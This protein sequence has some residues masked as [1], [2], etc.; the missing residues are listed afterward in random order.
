VEPLFLSIYDADGG[1]F[2]EGNQTLQGYF[3]RFHFSEETLSTHFLFLGSTGTGKTNAIIQFVNI[4]KNEMMGKDD[5]MI[6]FDTKGDYYSHFFDKNRG[7]VVISNLDFDGK[8]NWNIFEEIKIDEKSSWGQDAL[9]ISLEIFDE[10][11]RNS[12]DQYFPM[13]AMDVTRASLIALLLNSDKD[14][15]Q[16]TNRDLYKTLANSGPEELKNLI[17]TYPDLSGA[18]I[19]IRDPYSGQTQGVMGEIKQSME[20]IFSGKFGQPGN[21]SVRRFVRERGGKTLFIEYDSTYGKLLTPVYRLLIDLSIKEALG[22]KQ[23]G[24]RNVYFVIDE[25]GLL[26]NLYHIEDAVNFGRGLGVKFLVGT[27]SVNQVSSSY[28]NERAKSILASFG[29]V[30]GFRLNDKESKEIIANRYG[31][32]MALLTKKSQVPSEPLFHTVVKS[33][34]VEPL[35]ISLLKTGQSIVS[36]SGHKPHIFQFRKVI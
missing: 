16:R 31:E 7:D 2:G 26:P 11:I 33:E 14:G 4:I 35:L 15:I 1:D 3:G 27:Q 18:A 12:K 5:V 36:I 19:H 17:T 25:F 28:G 34:V 24:R 8:E 13:A 21:F 23:M 10:S 9:E 29:V 22:R 6:I 20:K 32:Y 30:F